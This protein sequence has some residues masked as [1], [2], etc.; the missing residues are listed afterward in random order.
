MDYPKLRPVEIFPVEAE[1]RQLLYLRDP[2]Q[3]V[4][5]PV[6]VPREVLPI[7][8]YFDGEHSILDIQTAYARQTGDILFSDNIHQLIESLDSHLMMDSEKFDEHRKRIETEFREMKTRPATHAGA[9]YPTDGEE[10]NRTLMGYFQPP[11]GPGSPESTASNTSLVGAIAPHIDLRRGG[12]CFAYAY[13][14]IIEQS[15]AEVFVILGVKHT[16]YRGMYTAT[17]KDFETP[18]GTVKTDTDFVDLLAQYYQGNLLE[19]EFFHKNEHSIEFQVI[20]LQALLG[21][22]RSFRIVPII[23]GS[24]DELLISGRHPRDEPSVQGF[25]E[26]LKRAIDESGSSVCILASVDFSHIGGRFGDQSSLNT[27]A[28][29]RIREEDLEML[30]AAESVDVEAF[31]DTVRQTENRRR[32]DGVCPIYTLL[33][34]LQPTSGKLLRYD[35]GLEREMNSV[36]TFASMGFYR[37]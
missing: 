5:E 7:L 19:D 35:Q 18:L 6:I 8:Q 25:I 28:L 27:V 34:T 16:G 9:A 24:F 10:L 13:K 14:E 37:G 12:T 21:E 30:H 33:E 22:K 31:L 32:V 20:F 2:F 3:Y 29:E 4:T 26:T 1:D 23:C 15:N 36:V 11:D 17:Y